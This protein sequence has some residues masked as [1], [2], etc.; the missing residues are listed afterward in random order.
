MAPPAL[1]APPDA[2]P[3][4]TSTAEPRAATDCSWSWRCSRP[5]PTDRASTRSICHRP[6]PEPTLFSRPL[7][8]AGAQKAVPSKPEAEGRVRQPRSR[9]RSPI[10]P[11][12]RSRPAPRPIEPGAPAPRRGLVELGAVLGA[13]P[14]IVDADQSQPGQQAAHRGVPAGRGPGATIVLGFPENKGFLRENAERKRAAFETEIGPVLGR[15]SRCVA[16]CRTSSS[17]SA[18][19]GGRSRRAGRR[20]SRTIW[21]TSRKSNR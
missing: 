14:E 9:S 20:S 18:A 8:A 2:S 7:R 19:P 6:P 16:S 15:P 13:W 5:D 12:V 17:C 10:Q 11:D 4:S 3:A 1:P 21:S